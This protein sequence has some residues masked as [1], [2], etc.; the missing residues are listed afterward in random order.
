MS[1]LSP[2]RSKVKGVF[3]L[4]YRKTDMTLLN[5]IKEASRVLLG[6][7][8]IYSSSNFQLFTCFDLSADL[9]AGVLVA[10]K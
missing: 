7:P 10:V 4:T 6:T 3:Y 1:L 2:L 8:R 9:G 5:L